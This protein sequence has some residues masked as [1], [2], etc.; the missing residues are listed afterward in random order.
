MG[1]WVSHSITGA[2]LHQPLE[3]AV[4]RRRNNIVGYEAGICTHMRHGAPL[5]LRCS[6]I[7]VAEHGQ[8]FCGD[9]LGDG[10]LSHRLFG[11]AFNWFDKIGRPSLKHRAPE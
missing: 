6:P 1:V 7:C 8:E 11:E 4:D 2:Q 3:A 9:G 10:S 5:G